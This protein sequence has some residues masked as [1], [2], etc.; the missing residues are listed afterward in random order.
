VHVAEFKVTV[1][2]ILTHFM[3]K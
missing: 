1:V 3:L 2:M